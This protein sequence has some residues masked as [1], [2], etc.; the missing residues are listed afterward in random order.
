VTAKI[1]VREHDVLTVR[2]RVVRVSD[3]GEQFTLEVMGQRVT[4]TGFGLDIVKQEKGANWP[5]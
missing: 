5:G 1:E 3:D 4:G 2:L